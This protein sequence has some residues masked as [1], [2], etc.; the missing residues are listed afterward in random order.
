MEEIIPNIL[1]KIKDKYFETTDLS[2]DEPACMNCHRLIKDE[3]PIIIWTSEEKDCRELHFCQECA[4]QLG[5]ID[6]RR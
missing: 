5:I 3:I 1:V 6:L 4:S 2:L